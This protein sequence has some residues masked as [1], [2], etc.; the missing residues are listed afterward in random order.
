[1]TQTNFLKLAT[2]SSVL[3]QKSIIVFGKTENYKI[4]F[5]EWLNSDNRIYLETDNIK[6]CDY[7]QEWIKRHDKRDVLLSKNQRLLKGCFPFAQQAFGKT[8]GI[9]LS[10][11]Y[12][13]SA[14]PLQIIKVKN[15]LRKN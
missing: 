11:D 3:S 7:I 12:F 2:T 6:H 13:V 10:V 14:T 1:M 4:E 9:T 8:Y 15:A 5:L